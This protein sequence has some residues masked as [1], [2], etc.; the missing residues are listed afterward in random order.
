MPQGVC[1]AS[2]SLANNIQFYS[3]FFDNARQK[4]LVILN[5]HSLII[6]EIEILMYLLVICVLPLL[7]FLCL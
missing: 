7:T 2:F 1:R 3:F 5:P 4:E 6:R